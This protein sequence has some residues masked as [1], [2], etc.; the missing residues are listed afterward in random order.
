MSEKRKAIQT[1]WYSA[2]SAAMQADKYIELGLATAEQIR[3]AVES[4]VVRINCCGDIVPTVT[5]PN[6]VM[7]LPEHVITEMQKQTAE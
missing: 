1:V 2:R 5:N 4:G 7:W 6:P 3:M